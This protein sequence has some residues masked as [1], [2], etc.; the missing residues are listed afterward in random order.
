VATT[1]DLSVQ[2]S[3]FN[4]ISRARKALLLL[5]A[6]N[7]NTDITF[8]D[9]IRLLFICTHNS[10]RSQLAEVLSD[11]LA[12]HYDLP[13]HSFSGGTERTAFYYQMVDALKYHGVELIK[14][15]DS[16]NPYYHI[17][18]NPEKKYYSKCYDDSI[19][20]TKSFFAFMVCD[21]AA[22]ACP[23]VPGAKYRFPLKYEDP[24][25]FDDS[26]E[27]KE[28]YREKVVEVGT[29]LN[30]IFHMLHKYRLNA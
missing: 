14:S 27:V 15:S 29:E 4:K 26:I 3:D 25:V 5:I 20:P 1:F 17:E 24:K 2:L 8:N 10:R 22:E 11:L 19:N 18:S 12:Q 23:V 9:P 28:A 7:L 16:D 21:S 13:I 6:N 30:F